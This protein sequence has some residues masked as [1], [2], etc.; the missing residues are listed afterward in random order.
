METNTQKG[1][2]VLC[3]ALFIAGFLVGTFVKVPLLDT[4]MGE[5][6]TSVTDSVNSIVP[7]AL[8]GS[9][10]QESSADTKV[11]TEG[12]T[13]T[14]VVPA[15]TDSQKKMLESFGVD[16]EAVTVTASMIACA[17]AKLG[18][19]RIEEIKN[20]ATPSFLEGAS[21]MACYSQ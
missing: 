1:K 9:N 4:K 2:V 6:K 15:L 14:T 13:G 19:A 12:S 11:T 3:I 8:T 16:A 10:T 21:L 18:S 5:V 17:E 7:G 20:G